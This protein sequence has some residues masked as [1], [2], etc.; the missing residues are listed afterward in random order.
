MIEENGGKNVFLS[1]LGVNSETSLGQ[2]KEE[3]ER[4]EVV[5]TDADNETEVVDDTFE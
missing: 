2:A 1:V 5:M 4:Q 3:Y